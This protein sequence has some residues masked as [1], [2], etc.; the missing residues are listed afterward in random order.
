MRF[1]KSGICHTEFDKYYFT[2]EDFKHVEHKLVSYIYINLKC[3]ESAKYT[4]K[5]HLINKKMLII[6]KSPT[7]TRHF[8]YTES[9]N[10]I[11][12]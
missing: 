3:S 12:L 1:L 4:T 5:Y 11:Y 2:S 7:T 9:N 10:N 6:F 8:T